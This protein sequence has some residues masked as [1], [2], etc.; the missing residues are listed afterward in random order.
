[1]IRVGLVGFG[2]AGKV[3]HAPFIDAVEGLELAAVVERHSRNAEAAYPG[4]TTYDS[5]TSMLSDPTIDLVVVA[6]PNASHAALAEEALAAARHVVVDKPVAPAADEIAGLM[7][8]AKTQGRLL[9]P[10]HNRRWDG[11]FQTLLQVIYEQL[12]G[13]IVYFESTFDRWRPVAPTGVWRNDGS[14]ATGLLLDL[15]THL[16]DQS[17]VLFGLPE[18]VS[19]EVS[20]ERDGSLSIDAFTVRLRHPNVTVMLSANALASQPR[21]RF[22]LR[23]TNGNFVKYGLDPQEDRLKRDPKFAQEGWGEEPEAAWGKLAVMEDGALVER[24]VETIPGSYRNYYA[25]VRDAILGKAPA[26][27]EALDAWRV[28]RILEWAMQSSEERREIP[29]VWDL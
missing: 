10:F 28:A 4:V 19:A 6:T 25:G 20:R 12:A 22:T 8:L 17:L 27:V 26:P 15:C 11:D 2:M 21:P 13:R 18:G 29:C 3:F 14:A 24:R 9:I 16:A 1:M 7:R 23:G 5:L